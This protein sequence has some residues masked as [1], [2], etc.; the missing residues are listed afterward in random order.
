MKF[1]EHKPL[2]I[3]LLVPSHKGQGE[4]DF[5]ATNR[6]QTQLRSKDIAEGVILDFG[7]NMKSGFWSG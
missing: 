4:Q 7:Y 5:L 6:I 3:E 2:I 1:V